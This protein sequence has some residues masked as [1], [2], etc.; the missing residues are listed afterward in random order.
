[1][2]T[3]SREP[4]LSTG[5]I[6]IHSF[7]SIV[8]HCAPSAVQTNFHTS[9]IWSSSSNEPDASIIASYNVHFQV[10]MYIIAKRSTYSQL[11]ML[12]SCLV[13]LTCV[14]SYTS[15]FTMAIWTEVISPNSLTG[16]PWT[17]NESCFSSGTQ[18]VI[19]KDGASA[20]TKVGIGVCYCTCC[21]SYI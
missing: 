8:T 14:T 2:L 16:R 10:C 21:C 5:H 12:V 1:M 7:P 6:S 17:V 13:V 19:Q 4:K 20:T 9:F 11:S 3:V 15:I 18:Q